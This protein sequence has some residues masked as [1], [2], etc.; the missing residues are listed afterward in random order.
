M[1]KVFKNIVAGT[2]LLSLVFTLSGCGEKKKYDEAMNLYNSG[3]FRAAANIFEELG[4][5]EDSETMLQSCEYE[6]TV[7]RQ[8]IWALSQGLHKRWILA[9]GD[10]AEAKTVMV[11][12]TELTVGD[13]YPQEVYITAEL[14][15]LIEFKTATFD[16]K[17]LQEKA[18]TYIAALEEGIEAEKYENT[19]VVKYSE[20]RNEVYMT[21]AVLI[22]DFYN[23]YGM[24]VSENDMSVL[25][26]FLDSAEAIKAEQK[27]EAEELQ[28]QQQK[29]E[30]LKA[31][32]ANNFKYTV[33]LVSEAY[34]Y[35]YYEI[36]YEFANDSTYTIEDLYVE[37]NYFN[38]DGAKTNDYTNVYED[39]QAGETL[40][41]QSEVYLTDSDVMPTGTVK[42]GELSFRVDGTNYSNVQ[43]W[44]E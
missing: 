10:T 1:K 38:D 25:K 22:S 39:I 18:L 36:K 21:R 30:E 32:L 33:E 14:E 19:D 9:D 41:G 23:N 15:G 20:M 42:V 12:G 4:T 11:D 17:D 35:Y 8:F 7:D 31:L 2:L 6:L 37:F 16:D 26:D 24:K 3:D 5:Y 13:T 28:A 27:K 40:M 43:S 34:G 29:E 44:L